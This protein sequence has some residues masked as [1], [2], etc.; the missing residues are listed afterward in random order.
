MKLYNKFLTGVGIIAAVFI[1]II[2]LLSNNI[3]L[4]DYTKIEKKSIIANLERVNNVI[5]GEVENISAFVKDY[6]TWDDSYVFSE[7]KNEE[8][9]S[10]N[11]DTLSSFKTFEINFMRP[12]A[13]VP[14]H[15]WW[16][17]QSPVPSTRDCLL[18]VRWR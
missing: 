10:S 15:N 12:R 13:R 16:P 1:M 7:N 8:Y 3:L 18:Y 14:R 2:L 17:G 6:S 11:F 4:S 5:N 9:I